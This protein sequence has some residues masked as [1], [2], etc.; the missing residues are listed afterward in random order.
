MKITIN[1]HADVTLSIEACTLDTREDASAFLD[2]VRR[3]MDA[4]WPQRPPSTAEQDGLL[5]MQK[6]A[7]IARMRRAG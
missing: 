5:Q 7:D 3:S 6:E 2:V 1:L 4:V